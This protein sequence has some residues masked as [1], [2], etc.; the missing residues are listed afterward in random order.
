[1]SAAAQPIACGFIGLGSQGAPMARRMIEAGFPTT[2]WARRPEA[3]EPYRGT[4]ARFAA[5]LPELAA[6]VEHVGVCVVADEDVRQVCD[7]L[8]PALRRGARIAIHSTVHPDTC[9]A[10][11]AQA[12][13]RGVRVIDAPVSGGSPA[14]EAGALTVMLGGD[15]DD[16]AAARPVFES[17]GRLIVRLGE[18]GAGQHAKLI[19][20]TLMAANLGVAHDA[21][22]AG[23]LLGLSREALVEL[24]SASSGRSFALEVRARLPSPAVF[25]HGASLLQKDVRLLGE[26]LGQGDEGFRHLR[27]AAV[28]YLDLCTA[29]GPMRSG[30]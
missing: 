22:I 3:L 16:I 13:A 21:L 30:G 28:T 24:L 5:T 29:P 17:F 9:R 27:D 19:N 25:A 12:A 11:A 1:V 26:V 8:I 10:V 14:A 7:Q 2:L 4:G 15:P 23:E 20:N 6:E 18:I